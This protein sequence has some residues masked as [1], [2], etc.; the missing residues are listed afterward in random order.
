VLWLVYGFSLAFGTND[1]ADANGYIGS[2]SQYLGT[3]VFPSEIWMAGGASTGIATYTVLAFQMMFAII[4]VALI[5]GAIS[6]RTKFAGWLLSPRAGS[7]WSTFRWRTGSGA[8]VLSRPRFTLW[9]SPVEPRCT[10][11][12]VPRP[13][14]GARARQSGGW[15]KD[16][17]KPHNVRSWRSAPACCGSAGSASTPARS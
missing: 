16:K 10:S 2:F 14:A 12:P 17:I 4:T 8:V 7:R 3:K 6:D 13:R 15:P 9:T 1:N 5:S 11:T